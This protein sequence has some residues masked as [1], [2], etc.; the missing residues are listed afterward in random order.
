M[1]WLLLLWHRHSLLLLLRHAETRLLLPLL[2]LGI[3]SLHHG[4]LL[5]LRLLLYHHGTVGRGRHSSTWTAHSHP[6]RVAFSKRLL[7]SLSLFLNFFH[8]LENT[9][10]GLGTSTR[11]PVHW[12]DRLHLL[13]LLLRGLLPLLGLL[14]LL[15]YLR[16]HFRMLHRFLRLVV[17]VVVGHGVV[18]CVHL[19]HSPPHHGGLLQPLLQLLLP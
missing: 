18:P 5:M 10:T 8:S 1:T 11:F 16:N 19:C 12:H 9:R 17:I 13:G 7:L 6:L 15:L 3:S 14:Y 4:T 2:L